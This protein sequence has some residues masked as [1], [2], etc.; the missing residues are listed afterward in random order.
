MLERLRKHLL[1]WLNV[2]LPLPPPTPTTDLTALKD[3]MD[4][5]EQLV[6][7]TLQT[8]DRQTD[9]GAEVPEFESIPDAHLGAR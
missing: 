9:F 8:A 3:R 6:M 5:L 1:M 7:N 2:P 4:S